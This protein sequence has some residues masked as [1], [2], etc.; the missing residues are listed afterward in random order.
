MDELPSYSTN[1][2]PFGKCFSGHETFAL[3]HFWL[4]K[5]IDLLVH[6]PAIFQREDA[7][8][9]FGVGKNMVSSIRYW[10]LAARVA[11]FDPK[12]RSN[13]LYPT[14]LGRNLFS[15][16]G[17]DPF[18]EDD[19]TL[20]LIHWN[21]ASTGTRLATW[22]WAFNRFHEFAFTKSNFV[23][24]LIRELQLFGWSDFSPTTIKRD[25]DCFVQTYLSRAADKIGLG[26]GIECPLSTLDILVPEPGSER[27]RFNIGPKETLPAPIF[28]YA[29]IHFWNSRNGASTLQL[30][31]ILHSEGSPSLVFKLD[32]ESVLNYLDK[33]G[34]VTSG[35][36]I[37]ED[38]PLVR[39]IVK[40]G[41]I[42]ADPIFLL[43]KY[44]GTQ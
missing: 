23:D 25:V 4:K 28:T 41:D 14:S 29:L 34:E 30:R 16:N 8:V 5:A 10:C 18:L 11:Q 37:F 20:W 36:I 24:L 43:E 1:G 22:Y 3:R 13:H 42:P 31:E 7:I 44:Y 19:A 35:Y 2:L 32:Q 26:A 21:L 9:H 15:D 27:L 12:T 33:I 40:R 6:D 38:T 39:R 17:W